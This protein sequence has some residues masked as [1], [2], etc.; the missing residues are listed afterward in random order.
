MIRYNENDC[1][2]LN[3]FEILSEECQ[4]AVNGGCGS[5]LTIRDYIEEFIRDIV[6][7]D[8]GAFPGAP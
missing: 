1:R 4:L 2:A 5:N 7:Q 8:P 3:C 6:Q